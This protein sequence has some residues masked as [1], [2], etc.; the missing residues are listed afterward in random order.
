MMPPCH[1]L[2]FVAALPFLVGGAQADFSHSDLTPSDIDGMFIQA[3]AILD[4]RSIEDM[5]SVP[6]LLE[7]CRRAG[8][9]T[10]AL[11]LLDVYEGKFR[12]LEAKPKDAADLALDLA[13]SVMPENAGEE[14]KEARKEAMFR[15]AIYRE[16]GF[17]CSPSP[18]KA[19]L[20]MRKAAM[21]DYP[22]AR[23]EFARYLMNG[24]GHDQMPKIARKILMEEA[25]EHPRTPNLFFYLG[26][27]C[28]SGLGLP[29]PNHT[30][31]RKF[32]ELGAQLNDP[33]ATNNLAT[34]YERG[35]GIGRDA[36]EALRLYKK[37]AELGSKDAAVNMQRLAIKT[38]HKKAKHDVPPRQRAFNGL[39]RL[40]RA[41][42]LREETRHSLRQCARRQFLPE[43]FR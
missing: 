16:K 5:S 11:L 36:D 19:Y 27:I 4:D 15:Y 12:G 29:R 3:K 6:L 32:F 1:A 40:L 9:F 26:H 21:E 14:E 37:A 39:V 17:G 10:S 31:A 22:K 42:P 23:V 20:W 41:L 28:S 24:V 34:L 43:S 7:H 35:I 13:S 2:L 25:R 33:N 38:G 18:Q 30:M 8:S